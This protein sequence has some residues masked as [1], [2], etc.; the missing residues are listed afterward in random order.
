[1]K[2]KVK[3]WQ[4][5]IPPIRTITFHLRS[6]NI[7]KTTTYD[8]GNPGLD[9]DRHNNNQFNSATF[10]CL[11]KSRPGF[12]TSYVVVF[13]MFNDLRWKVIVRIGGIVLTGL[14]VI[15]TDCIG[16]CTSNYHT[17]T[18][19]TAPSGPGNRNIYTTEFATPVQS[20]ILV[21]IFLFSLIACSEC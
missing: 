6:L 18:T 11:S 16:S 15:Y 21:Q 19:T 8:V 10:L 13:F 17:I 4:S 20:V 12:P 1:M 5:T 2:R 3:Q 9:L 14:V 7:K